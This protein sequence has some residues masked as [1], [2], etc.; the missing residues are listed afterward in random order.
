MATTP[1][2]D[3]LTGVLLGTAVGDAL[4]LPYENLSRRRLA[5]FLGAGPLRHRVLFGRGL[6][7]DDTEH[8]AFVGR[9]LLAAPQDADRFARALA[10]DL[11][12][13]FACLPIALGRAT[14]QA[15]VKLWLGFPPHR[16]GV[17]SAGNGPAM[18]APLLGAFLGHDPP[19]LRAFVR[20]ST[21]LTH[22]DLKAERGALLVALAAYL[23]ATAGPEGVTPEAFRQALQDGGFEPDADLAHTMAVMAEHRERGASVAELAEALGL[24]GRVSGYVYHTAPAAVYAW[25]RWPGDFRQAVTA[26]IALGGDTDTTGAITGGLVGATVGAAGVP[27]DWLAG[28]ADRPFSVTWLR[29]LGAALASGAA[30]PHLAWPLLLARNLLF[31]PVVLAHAGRRLLPPY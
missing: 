30:P 21:R 22:T 23:G 18:R 4:G 2:R 31:V 17:W 13:W 14:L 26:V 29:Q 16:S 19:R 1:A 27:A 15:C 5:R 10:W 11:R 20:A 7:S 28:L 25:L 24:R 12:R 3:P 6:V 9:A 8:A